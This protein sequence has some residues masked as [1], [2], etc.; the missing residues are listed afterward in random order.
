[1]CRTIPSGSI[2][3]VKKTRLNVDCA[4][5]NDSSNQRLHG[6]REESKVNLQN[7][8]GVADTSDG[9]AGRTFS[10][11]GE[12]GD[13]EGRG[14]NAYELCNGDLSSE[15]DE[16]EDMSLTGDQVHFIHTFLYS[17]ALFTQRS[18]SYGPALPSRILLITDGR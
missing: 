3:T 14:A 2:P 4:E 12:S 17:M 13:T 9:E 10:F 8:F 15:L 16:D 18:E 7:A 5:S 6:I 11:F 1:M